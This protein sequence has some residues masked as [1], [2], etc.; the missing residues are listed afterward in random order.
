MKTIEILRIVNLQFKEIYVVGGIFRDILMQKKYSIKKSCDIDI[1]VKNL[2]VN[3]LKKICTKYSLPFIVLDEKNKIYRVISK[4][5]EVRI[6]FSNYKDLYKDIIRRDFTINTLFMPLSEFITQYSKNKFDVSKV[7]DYFN[8]IKDI[9]QKKIKLVNKNSLSDD[10][11]RIL[12]AARFMS[13]GFHPDA[14]VEQE[15]RKNVKKLNKISKERIVDE[16]KKIFSVKSYN[17]LEW[18]DKNKILDSIFSEIKFVKQKGK[19]TKFKKFYFH[20]EGLWQ[21]IKLT[22]KKVEFVLENLKLILG[23]HSKSVTE[24]LKKYPNAVFDIK[25]ASLFHDI[26][27]PHVLKNIDGRI[28]FFYHEEKSKEITYKILKRMK[29]SNNET[30][31]ICSLVENHMRIGNLCHAKELTEK[32]IFRLFNQLDDKIFPLII[33]SLAD[34]YSYD[35]I[36]ERK[37]DLE[38]NEMPVFKKFVKKIIKKYCD[39]KKNKSIPKLIDGTVLIKKFGLSEGPMIGKILE[40]VREAQFLKK[41]STKSEAE[42]LVRRIINDL[43]TN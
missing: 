33:I 1:I 2:K 28:R 11:L 13:I 26:A 37:K 25:M 39:Y 3:N 7:V 36:P 20:K 29:I 27:K 5:D 18:M 40:Q 24:Y 17:V 41:I 9:K 4:D 10:A 19:N 30:E 35:S 14:N 43:E 6:D 32:G 31:L 8:G 38:L 21:H 23:V 34:R 42:S 22:Y 12:R 16:L 15:V